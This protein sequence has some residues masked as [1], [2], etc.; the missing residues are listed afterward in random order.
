[1]GFS[2][3]YNR[4]ETLKD[5][6]TDRQLLMMLTDIVS[7]GGNLLLDIGPRADGGIP[8]VME[9]RLNQLGRWLRAERRG[10]LRHSRLVAPGAV[11]RGQ[12]SASGAIGIHVRIRHLKDGRHSARRDMRGS[13]HSLRRSRIRFTRF[14]RAGRKRNLY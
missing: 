12:D 14:F 10:D 9:E 8:V 13:R 1:M 7:R 5:Y 4:N 2:Y 11:E 3:G 6:H